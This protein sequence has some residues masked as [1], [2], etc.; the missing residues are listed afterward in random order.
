M[1]RDDA[2][3]KNAGEKTRRMSL[4]ASALAGTWI[5]LFSQ[6]YPVLSPN[7]GGF[8]VSFSF[9]L[10][11]NFTCCAAEEEEEEGD[12]PAILTGLDKGWYL[13]LV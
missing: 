11:S 1:D 10:I 2:P 7:V 9:G 5:E 4:G 6:P 8:T 3:C 13:R 12:V